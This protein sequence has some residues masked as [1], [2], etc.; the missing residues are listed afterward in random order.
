[1][2]PTS[3]RE[4][5][6]LFSEMIETG[7]FE[8][9]G[10]NLIRAT[11]TND[12]VQRLEI[13]QKGYK[14]RMIESLR[15]DF[16]D[17]VFEIGDEKFKEIASK[18]LDANPSRFWSLAEV[19]LEFPSFLKTILPSLYKQACINLLELKARYAKGIE[20][21]SLVSLE[22]VKSGKPFRIVRNPTL[23]IFI[24]SEFRLITYRTRKSIFSSELTSQGM[25]LIELTQKPSDPDELTSRLEGL[26]CD[27]NQM[28]QL[29][30]DWIRDEIL[31]CE[32]F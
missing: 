11:S 28:A 27:L 15:D 20:E 23:Q 12:A 24:D 14:I 10:L 17:I 30:S 32:H 21:L 8:S 2:A 16:E 4:I 26:G 7:E 9:S 1:M 22:D 31:Y 19:S 3:L 18:Y 25:L 29:L 6:N 5:Q 13:Y